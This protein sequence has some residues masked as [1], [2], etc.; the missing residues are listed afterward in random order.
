M[1]RL[2]ALTAAAVLAVLTPREAAARFDCAPGAATT[3]LMVDRT[4]AYDAV[5]LDR[6]N[7]GL[8]TVIERLATGERLVVRT[9]TDDAMTADSVFQGCVP[10]CSGMMSLFTCSPSRTQM[11]RKA[12]L[13]DLKASLHEHLSPVAQY[14]RSEIADSIAEATRASGTV[15]ELLVYSDMLENS[16]VLSWS[17]LATAKPGDALAIVNDAGIR[18]ALKDA[19]VTVWGFGRS[20]D[21]DRRALS[22]QLRRDLIEFW[23]AWFRLGGATRVRIGA[24]FP[25]E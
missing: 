1:L 7:G 16:R 14:P 21:A 6:L 20:H 25:L 22:P 15:R 24:D 23:S 3:L 5:D 13:H 12:F 4:T 8:Q 9:M 11:E 19:S 10:G 18:A 2:L 17:R